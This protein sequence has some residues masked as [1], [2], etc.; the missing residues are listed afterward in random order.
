MYETRPSVD[1]FDLNTVH[2]SDDFVI[3]LGGENK[4]VFFVGRTSGDRL[5]SLELDYEPRAVEADGDDVW[6]LTD[7]GIYKIDAGGGTAPEIDDFWSSTTGPCGPWIVLMSGKLLAPAF[8]G[9]RSIDPTT[10]DVETLSLPVIGPNTVATTD[11]TNLFVFD[12]DRGKVHVFEVD[13]HDNLNWL[14][15]TTISGS[16]GCFK[17]VVD[18]DEI[19]LACL[20]RLLRIDISDASEPEIAEISGV[21][22]YRLTDLTVVDTG[23]YWLGTDERTGFSVSQ[24]HRG[25]AYGDFDVTNSLLHVAFPDTSRWAFTDVVPYVESGDFDTLVDAVDTEFETL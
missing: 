11:G 8:H 25:K 13:S 21:L 4:T 7:S 12:R 3:G 2:V 24:V 14:G 9:V 20:H 17:A 15:D 1:H 22:P 5:G 6:V 19:I 18:G 23:K 16:R 10:G